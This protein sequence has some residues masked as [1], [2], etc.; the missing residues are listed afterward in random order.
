MSEPLFD[1]YIFAKITETEIGKI[2]TVDGVVN[3]LY[4]KG[5]PATIH[6][7]EIEAI[8][9]FTNDFQEI[10]LEKTVINPNEEVN[11]VDGPK[12]VIDG[13][14][15]TIR[16]TTIKVN[17][18]SIGFMMIAKID[19]KNVIGREISLGSTRLLHQS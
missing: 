4:W 12:Y 6:E 15:L 11:V 17:L 8:R 7:N 5:N 3:L 19:S 14:L 13:N 1:S 16:N 9:E 18:P 10:H 2:K